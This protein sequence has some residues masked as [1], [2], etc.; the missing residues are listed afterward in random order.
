MKQRWHR[1]FGHTFVLSPYRTAYIDIFGDYR[2]NQPQFECS[3]GY[4]WAPYAPWWTPTRK[5]RWL[6][7]R[8]N[9]PVDQLPERATAE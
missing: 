4:S 3:C 2:T 7:Y 9:T 1:L 8:L 5:D 6:P